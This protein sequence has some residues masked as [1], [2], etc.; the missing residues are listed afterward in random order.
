MKL[1]QH[2]AI[3][4]V[5][6][7]LVWVLFR[8]VAASAACFLAG[9]FLDI[10][11]L[12]D[13]V[14]NYGW[15]IRPKRL[16]R[17]FEYE[18]FENIFLFLHSWEFVAVYLVFLWLI[19]WQPVAMGALIGIGV[20]LFLDHFFNKH[21]VFAYFISY[22]LRHGFSARHFYGAKEYRQ[23]LKQQRKSRPA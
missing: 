4:A 10:D 16:F 22:R 3:S 21:S 19:N 18:V 14:Y 20:H 7:A 1:V 9:V 17:A 15:N 23:R 8:S 13:Y 12:I 2:I 5:V 11:H 6:A